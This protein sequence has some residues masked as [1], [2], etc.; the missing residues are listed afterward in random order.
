M[1]T[2]IDCGAGV[3]GDMLLG[4]LAGIGLPMREFEKVLRGTLPGEGWSLRFKKVER[5]GWPA[6]SFTLEGDRPIKS[7][8]QMIN[9]I[10]NSRLPRIVRERALSTF[11]A[12]RWAEAQAHERAQGEFDPQGLGRLDTLVDVV[13]CSWGFWRLGLSDV[14]AS[15][16]NTGRLAPATAHLLKRHRVPAFS[17]TP[18]YELATPTGV[19]LLAVLAG[20]FEAMPAMRVE[21]SG[22]GAGQRDR[23]GRPNVLAIHQGSPENFS[24]IRQ[25]PVV[26][27]ETVIDDM[28]PRLYPHVSDLLFQAGALDAW[29]ASIGMKKGR[30]GISYSVL[31]RPEKERDLL[32]ILFRETTTLGVRRHP[33]Q[34]W[35]LPRQQRGVRKFALLPG[36]QRKSSLEFEPVR[37]RAF[38][39]RV[40]LRKL[41]K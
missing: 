8:A 35:V 28:D 6:W 26:L 37:R 25:E 20:H 39:R 33:L 3:A 16:V 30:P 15:P 21:A 22:Y 7:A 17:D 40:P 14:I 9:I 12:L 11:E 5:A 34:R 24:P 31:C 23:R 38:S 2:Y 41:L 36:G 32:Q 4:A 27:L 29:W 10:R 1:K 19:A 13:G 18:E